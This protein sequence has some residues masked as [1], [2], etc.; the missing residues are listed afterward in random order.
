MAR[1]T[2]G[3]SLKGECVVVVEAPSRD[4][5]RDRVQP[6]ICDEVA[7]SCEPGDASVFSDE[8]LKAYARSLLDKGLAP[9]AAAKALAKERGLS[10]A[11]AY[12]LV[13]KAVQDHDF[14][15]KTS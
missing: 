10:R 15:E 2:K 7:L 8:D 9:T 11:K 4:E 13:V 3:R 12:G 14:C 5:V 1:E 6:V